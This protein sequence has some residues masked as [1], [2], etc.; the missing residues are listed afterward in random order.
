[1]EV[2][3]LPSADSAGSSSRCGCDLE[4]GLQRLRLLQLELE[5][6]HLRANQDYEDEIRSLRERLDT[7]D[8][9]RSE[10]RLDVNHHPDLAHRPSAM[11]L[12][13]D[14]LAQTPTAPLG[15]IKGILSL[16][17]ELLMQILEYS[18]LDLDRL[19]GNRLFIKPSCFFCTSFPLWD[20]PALPI[21]VPLLMCS[22]ELHR[23]I[24]TII[25]QYATIVVDLDRRKCSHE[26]SITSVL[27]RHTLLPYVQKI[28]L[29][30]EPCAEA[31][32]DNT[33]DGYTKRLYCRVNRERSILDTISLLKATLPNLRTIN[34]TVKI[35]VVAFISRDSRQMLGPN[36]DEM[37]LSDVNVPAA[38]SYH[39][40]FSSILQDLASTSTRQQT[41]LRIWLGNSPAGRFM[42][43]L[44]PSCNPVYSDLGEQEITRLSVL[45]GPCHIS[46]V[47][48][49]RLKPGAEH[50][51]L[52]V[53]LEH[54]LTH[55][56]T[57][58]VFA[59]TVRESKSAATKAI[60]E[61]MHSHHLLGPIHQILPKVN[62]LDFFH[63]LA[64]FYWSDGTRDEWSCLEHLANN[65]NHD[66]GPQTMDKVEVFERLLK[67]AFS[68]ARDAHFWHK[69]RRENNT[70]RH[71]REYV[72]HE[73][74]YTT[75]W[76][77]S[78]SNRS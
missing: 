41:D 21:L 56:L 19:L 11:A 68:D 76:K 47:Q 7:Y 32:P 57:R 10:S 16:P 51:D 77:G 48:D 35:A 70:A 22:K 49:P 12:E 53:R 58:D 60:S 2:P 31:S 39:L 74:E 24:M 34:W 1:M 5:Q 45:L 42:E 25:Y 43:D 6:A 23:R 55:R 29:M 71:E 61:F 20:T 9:L 54:L 4:K 18:G 75:L 59:S 69:E 13:K 8:G 38:L 44:F 27:A 72:K 52:R 62:H 15:R 65:P 30:I 66:F 17:T 46:N 3:K 40:C 64:T 37:L 73:R 14:D 26:D 28:D 50:V 63:N 36:E 33:L 78:A 67:M